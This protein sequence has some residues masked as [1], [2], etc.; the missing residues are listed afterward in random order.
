L[1]AGADTYIN[2]ARDRDSDPGLGPW[3]WDTWVY[4]ASKACQAIHL[5]AYASQV[6]RLWFGHGNDVAYVKLSSGGGAPDVEDSAYEFTLVG[7]RFSTK[8]H[9]GDWGPK[10]FP[11]IVV[12]GKNLTATRYWDIYFSVDGGAFSNL[13]AAAVGMRIN[14]D[15]R[16]VFFLPDTA[17]GREVQYRYDYVGNVASQAGELNLV[18]GF[19][20]PQS[21]K[22]PVYTVQLLLSRG[23]YHDA[24]IE[25][26][27]PIEQFNDLEVLVKQ[28]NSVGGSG[29]WGEGQKVW[30]RGLQLVEVLQEGDRE[31]DL[32]VEAILQK[33]EES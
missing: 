10:D 27:S 25:Q 6:P 29:P 18:E 21:R 7:N 31:P 11:K 8:Y 26:R 12:V 16:K 33:R 1:G 2:V 3:T 9:F 23:Q 28:A 15:G 19:A 32:L 4:L 24:G 30:V 5:S 20:A 14:S 22:V 17:V 13:D